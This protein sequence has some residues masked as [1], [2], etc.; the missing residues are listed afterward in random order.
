MS[1]KGNRLVKPVHRSRRR[2][3]CGVLKPSNLGHLQL[4]V[5]D[6]TARYRPVNSEVEPILFS[7]SA[8][9]SA[10]LI[11]FEAFFLSATLSMIK[12]A[13]P[14]LFEKLQLI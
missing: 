1:Y 3:K 4:H 2:T 8:P 6:G 14:I 12:E 7:P 9:A 13:S 10:H 5:D 11:L